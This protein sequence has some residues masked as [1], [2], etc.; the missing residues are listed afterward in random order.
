[1]KHIIETLQ[2]GLSFGHNFVDF[3]VV[4]SFPLQADIPFMFFFF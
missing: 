4:D 1:V 2:Q 3:V